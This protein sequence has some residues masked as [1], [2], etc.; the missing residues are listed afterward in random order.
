MKVD[1]ELPPFND[2]PAQDILVLKIID[3]VASMNVFIGAIG[4]EEMKE[5]EE[6]QSQVKLENCHITV[7]AS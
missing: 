3:S 5:S 7:E 6:I 4:G 2:D 1:S